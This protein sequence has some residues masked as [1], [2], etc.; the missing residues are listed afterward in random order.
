VRLVDN[1]KQISRRAAIG[2]ALRRTDDADESVFYI[3]DPDE[4]KRTYDY[5]LDGDFD[6]IALR[7]HYLRLA[8]LCGDAELS[9][10]LAEVV[11]PAGRTPITLRLADR[12][13]MG[14]SCVAMAPVGALEL[15]MGIDAE[16]RS[17][18]FRD[19]NAE[20]IAAVGLEAHKAF[21]TIDHGVASTP[22]GA[23]LSLSVIPY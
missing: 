14:T 15:F 7:S 19:K 12:D 10:N 16:V 23:V 2:L 5:K 13:V 22:D 21:N 6:H 18:L 11:V 9:S 4:G 17:I 20:M 1:T 3:G 8:A